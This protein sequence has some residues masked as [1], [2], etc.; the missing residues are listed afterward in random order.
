[1]STTVVFPRLD[2]DMQEG[3]IIDWLVDV[4]DQVGAGDEIAEMETAKVTAAIE[5]PSAGVV[6]AILVEAGE[7]TPVGAPIAVI[8]KAGEDLPPEA[9]GGASARAPRESEASMEQT[10]G[11]KPP[12]TILDVPDDIESRSLNLPIDRTSWSRPHKLTPRARYE[13]RKEGQSWETILKRKPAPARPEKAQQPTVA[14]EGGRR[15]E[16]SGMRLATIRTVEASWRIPQFSVESLVPTAALQSML[17]E[18]RRLAPNAG[19]TVT[20][21]IAVTMAKAARAVPEVNAWF[22]GE[23][24]RYFDEVDLSL[25]IQTEQGLYVPVIRSVHH[26]GVRSIAEERRELVEAAR[27]GR[28]KQEQLQPG[29]IALS[30]LGM[31]NIHRFNAILYPPQ[32]AILAVGRAQADQ[33]DMPVWLTLTVDHRVVDGAIAA[34]YLE[35]LQDLFANPVLLLV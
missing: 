20:D 19:V 25:M 4:G 7:V 27:A 30:N 2:Q 22:E 3:T 23:A 11:E 35:A 16:L 24:I 29:T 34:R 10:N 18:V 26:R 28:L 21:M 15:V 17:E 33:P 14:R 32:V 13:A 1:M 12:A 6:L 31:F 8:G 9:A 5:S